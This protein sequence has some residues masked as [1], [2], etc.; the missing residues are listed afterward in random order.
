MGLLFPGMKEAV[1]KVHDEA[2]IITRVQIPMHYQFLKHA[3]IHALS[4]D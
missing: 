1:V 3:C 2:I 4:Y